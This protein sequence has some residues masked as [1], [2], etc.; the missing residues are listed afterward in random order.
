M[1]QFLSKILAIKVFNANIDIFLSMKSFMQ[2]N[3]LNS[4]RGKEYVTL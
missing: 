1:R 3:Q 4:S 2:K